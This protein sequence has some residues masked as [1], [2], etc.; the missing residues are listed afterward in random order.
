MT[1]RLCLSHLPVGAKDP[2]AHPH[3]WLLVLGVPPTGNVFPR[4]CTGPPPPSGLDT[5]LGCSELP[6]SEEAASG[7]IHFHSLSASCRA[8]GRFFSLR[9]HHSAVALQSLP[10]NSQETGFLLP[11]R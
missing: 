7:I 8:C 6:A 2:A 4:L 1:E 9:P 11:A 5:S 3:S 10:R